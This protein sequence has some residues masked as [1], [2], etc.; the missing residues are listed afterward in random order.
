MTLGIM[1]DAD[2]ATW[3]C[4][5]SSFLLLTII[6]TVLC[7]PLKPQSGLFTFTRI[8][9]SISW[10]LLPGVFGLGYLFRLLWVITSRFMTL[11]VARPWISPRALAR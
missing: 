2:R 3:W 9:P 1:L 8:R 7:M 4:D 5:R 10:A 6:P 11:F